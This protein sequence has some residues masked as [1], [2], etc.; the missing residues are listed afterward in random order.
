MEPDSENSVETENVMEGSAFDVH[1]YFDSKRNLDDF[2]IQDFTF[3]RID[4]SGV[5]RKK[6]S[7][8]QAIVIKLNMTLFKDKIWGLTVCT[9]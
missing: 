6:H 3:V 1:E 5:I 7:S 2:S 8:A 4:Y 9:P